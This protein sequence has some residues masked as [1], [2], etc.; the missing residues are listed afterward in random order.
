[1]PHLA[2]VWTGIRLVAEVNKWERGLEPTEKKV[3]IQGWEQT[4]FE[5]LKFILGSK[6]WGNKTKEIYYSLLSLKMI[7]F[8]LF[9]QASQS[10]MNFNISEWNLGNITLSTNQSGKM[11]YVPVCE[12]PVPVLF[13]FSSTYSQLSPCGHLALTDNPIIRTAAKSPAKTNYRRL[14]KIN[15]R[16][17]GL[18][19]LRTCI[20]GPYS[21]CNKGVGIRCS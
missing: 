9:P 2:V 21:V 15:S 1:M 5:I 3:N 10:S 14:T 16:Y 7:S 17:Y 20:R 8:V 11:F 18:S 13:R 4:I 6:A 12:R 19:L